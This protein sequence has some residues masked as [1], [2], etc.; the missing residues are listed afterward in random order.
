MSLE[1]IT[2]YHPNGQK[3]YQ[4]YYDETQP[5]GDQVAW[6]ENG[7]KELE[8][9]ELSESVELCTYWYESGQI[10]SKG[11]RTNYFETGLWTYWFENGNKKSEGCFEGED[12]CVG[13]WRYWHSN[14]ELACIG[15]LQ[16]YCGGGLWTFWDD[17]GNKIHEREYRDNELLDVWKNLRVEGCVDEL[18]E[19]FKHYI[20]N[21]N[22]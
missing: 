13:K 1:L 22:L 19:K 20:F 4:G 16:G 3:H 7:N 2:K 12:G 14:G 18:V 6:Y 8:S 11:I 5:V 21:V 15:I 9:I 10:K 17:A